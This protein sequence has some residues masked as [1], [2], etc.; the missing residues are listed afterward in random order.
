[1]NLDEVNKLWYDSKLIEGIN[2]GLN[3]YIRIVDGEYKGNN[4][5]VICLISL[6]PVT[7]LVEL[8]LSTSDCDA[9][10][11]QSDMESAE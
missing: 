10:V 11:L 2:F 5:S 4:A 3:E 7:Y 6:E 8:D 9:V 1:M